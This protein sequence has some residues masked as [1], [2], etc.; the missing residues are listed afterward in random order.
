MEATMIPIDSTRLFLDAE[1]RRVMRGWKGHRRFWCSGAHAITRLLDQ[2]EATEESLRDAFALLPP[3]RVR[4]VRPDTEAV[5]AYVILGEGRR[6]VGHL[7]ANGETD[8]G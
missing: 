7:V 5:V 1:E 2:L 4:L 8:G 6:R 3:D